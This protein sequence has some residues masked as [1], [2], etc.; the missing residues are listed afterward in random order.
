MGTWLEELWN[1]IT[2]TASN[3]VDTVSSA[4]S[5]SGPSTA[6][7]NAEPFD[8]G[9]IMSA[10]QQ[11]IGLGLPDTVESMTPGKDNWYAAS[12]N[13][14]EPTSFFDSLK[15]GAK[16]AWDKDPMKVL[17]FAGGAIG[18]AYTAEE[19][20]K[21]AEKLAQSRLN[22]QN[23]QASIEKAKIDAYNAS[24]NGTPTRTPVRGK[25]LTRLD[26][27]PIYNNGILRG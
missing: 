16:K 14:T 19:K 3:V 1:G 24:F 9:S 8:W 22:E 17:E 15:S 21:A 2:D 25:P 6:T 23:N 4:L 18:G 10:S 13:E 5:G 26:G 27:T 11:T 20:R 7:Y 12:Q